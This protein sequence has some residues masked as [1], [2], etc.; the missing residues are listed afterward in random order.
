M[1][2]ENIIDSSDEFFNKNIDKNS[3]KKDMKKTSNTSEKKRNTKSTRLLEE[4]KPEPE[5]QC[6]CKGIAKKKTVGYKN[7]HSLKTHW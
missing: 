3:L 4:G 2:E 1:L 6:G 5:F 7:M